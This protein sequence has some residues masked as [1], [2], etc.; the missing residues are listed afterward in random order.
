MDVFSPKH[1]KSHF[2]YSLE[3]EEAL[4]LPLQELID[5]AVQAGWDTRTVIKALESVAQN[6]AIAYEQD[7]DPEDDPSEA[8]LVAQALEQGA[9]A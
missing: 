6:K 4:D 5:I 1:P 2:D 9:N 8:E 3:C 7:P